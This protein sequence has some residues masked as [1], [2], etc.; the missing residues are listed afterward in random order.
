MPN[1]GETVITSDQTTKKTPSPYDL[2]SSDTLGNVITQVK[3]KGEN[4]DEWARAICTSLRARRKW[5]FIDGS[6]YKPEDGSPQIEDWWTVNS[7]VVSW[8]LN[9][10][11]SNLRLM[12]SYK[13]DAKELW[14]DIR[15]R[16]SVING[17]RIHQLKCELAE[18]KQRGMSIIS[19]YRKSKCLWDDLGQY[20]PIPVCV[21]T[22]CNCD[23]NSKLQK[24]RETAYVHQ[25][26]MGLHSDIYGT[27][28]STL[29]AIEPL[30]T[31]NKV[32]STLI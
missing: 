18:T 14:D 9:T 21:C 20:N 29:L 19:Y 8:I 23:L 30:P 26:L 27:V 11:E 32:Y 3:L 4:Y 2:N 13:E 7:M 17:P 6:L 15:D 12:I 22:R 28:R 16:F 10:I 25:F 31:I 5:G 1:S 24:Q